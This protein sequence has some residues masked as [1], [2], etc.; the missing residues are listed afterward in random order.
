MSAEKL[1]RISYLVEAEFVGLGATPSSTSRNTSWMGD[2][3]TCM[4]GMRGYLAHGCACLD[5][6]VVEE[7][8]GEVNSSHRD[9][10]KVGCLAAQ[11]EVLTNEGPHIDRIYARPPGLDQ[12]DCDM[13]IPDT[14]KP[15]SRRP[16][17]RFVPPRRWGL[18]ESM[19]LSRMM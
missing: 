14:P 7:G 17:T 4:L 13:R 2:Y 1:A 18:I 8:L 19:S 5:S 6:N 16:R 12:V 3:G 11:F 9:T 10:R 15:Q